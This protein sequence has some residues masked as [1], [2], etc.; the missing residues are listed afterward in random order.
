M[1]PQTF[2]PA[3]PSRAGELSSTVGDEILVRGY[4]LS[5]QLMGRLTFTE[6]FLLDLDGELPSAEKTRL[7]DTVLVAL[8]EHG[9]T[10]STL[11]AR[12]VLEGAPEAIQG[13]VAAGILAAGSR[14]LGTVKP[15]AEFT[16]A[17]VSDGRPLDEAARHHVDR[18]LASGGKLPGLG[19]TLHS[20]VDPRVVVLRQVAEETGFAG[21]HVAALDAAAVAAEESLGRTLVS[22]AAGMVGA[23]LSELGYSSQICH[24]F[25]LIARAGGLVAHLSDELDRP[26]ARDLWVGQHHGPAR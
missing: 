5:S 17:I 1:A 26:I 11:A 15:A 20:A 12:L 4:S 6:M 23:I 9:V 3:D 10:P 14:F 25:P 2:E 21:Q 16:Q 18:V 7:V 19:H 8:M 13:A 24:G 22:N